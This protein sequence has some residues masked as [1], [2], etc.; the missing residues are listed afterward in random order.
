MCLG[1]VGRITEIWDQAGVPMARVDAGHGPFEACLLYVPDA[2]VDEPVLVHM[3]FV[4][5]VMDEE[6]YHE[7]VRLRAQLAKGS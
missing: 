4:T 6:Q 7:T 5:E 1:T 2:S 3:S